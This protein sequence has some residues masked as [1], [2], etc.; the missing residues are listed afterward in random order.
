MENLEFTFIKNRGFGE[1]IQDYL[2]LLKRIFRHFNS[3]IFKFIL[4]FLAI[5]LLLFFFLS[6]FGVGL[7]YSNALNDS[8]AFALPIL[9]ACFV[10][11]F[12][13]VFIPTF[14]MEYMFLLKEKGNTDFKGAEV[15]QRVKKHLGKYVKFFLA[16]LVVMLIIAIPFIIV[17]GI[18]V[19]IPLLGGIAIGILSACIGIVMVCGLFLYVEGKKEVFDSFTAS[20]R[21]I[22][23][24]IL[25]YGLTAYVFSLLIRIC[26]MLI[27]IIPSVILWIIAYNSIGFNEQ[28]FI[29]FG[30]KLI[31]SIMGTLVI[32]MFTISSIYIMSFYSLIYFS[33]LET[34]NKEGTLAQIEQIGMQDDQNI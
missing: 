33:S 25:V 14:G 34:T 21:L 17:A 24:K 9:I 19:F 1:L 23:K 7:F 13:F 10:G 18:L 16:S 5:F 4:P 6:S 8:A 32:L 27:T 30:G 2:S 15:W 22:K 31:L 3:C 26:L 11:F 28:I 29:S 12:Y 20:F